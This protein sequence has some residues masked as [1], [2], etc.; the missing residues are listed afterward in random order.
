[1]KEPVRRRP[2]I[3]ACA[4]ALTLI[5]ALALPAQAAEEVTLD[6]SRRTYIV[7]MAAEPVASY[8]GGV[9]GIAAT[10]PEP[11][12]KVDANS[13]NARRYRSH[14][15]DEARRVMRE[16]RVSESAKQ[17]EFEVAFSGF[18]AELTEAQAAQLGKAKGVVHVWEDELRH[19]DTVTTPDY[20]GLTGRRGVWQSEFGGADNA[21]KGM[22]IGVIDSGIDPDNPSFAAARRAK[23]P[24]GPFEC[25]TADDAAFRCSAKIVG[26]RFYGAEYGNDISHDV[27]S[28]RDT[29]GHG[30][31]TAGTAAGNHGV[32]AS[33]LGVDLGRAS[34]M[35]PAAHISVYKALWNTEDGRGT[36]TTSGLVQA[37][38][39]AVADGVDVINYSISGS[40]QYVVT[41][42][43]LAFMAAAHAGVFVS[44]SAGNSGSDGA[45]TVAHNSPWTMTVAASTHDR[46]VT[47]SLRLGNR[48]THKGVGYGGPLRNASMVLARDIPAAGRTA[49]DADLCLLGAVDDRRANGKLVVCTRGTN[50]FV[51]KGQEVQESGGAGMVVVNAPGGST[52]LNAII[53]GIPAIHLDAASG[54]AVK[55]YVS[56]TR[57]PTGTISATR[58][59]TVEAPQM[60]DFSSMGPALAG[61]GDLL[62]P[63]ITAPGVDVIAAYSQDPDTGAPRFES[64]QGTSM[65]AP[66]IAGLALLMKQENPRWSPMAVKSAMMTT[67]RQTTNKGNPISRGGEP[68]TPLDF[69]SGEVVPGKMFDPG[70][71][72][73]SN[74]GDWYVYACG[75]GQ[76]QLLGAAQL[77]DSLPDKDPSDLNYPSISIGSLAG[78]QT[79]TR[80]VTNM[81]RSTQTYTAQVQAPPGTTVKVSPKTIRVPARGTTTFTVTVSRTT[82]P[83]DAYTFGSLT[84]VPKSAKKGSDAGSVRSPIAVRPVLVA[85]PE[86]I[87]G[88]GT[89]GSAT[90]SVT[91][92]FTGTLSTDVDGL[93]ASTVTPVLVTRNPETIL[94]G[95]LPFVVPEGTRV[96]RLATF[97]DEVAAED[98]DLYLYRVEGQQLV[99]VELSG[100]EGSS[101]EV[102]VRDLAPGTYYAIIDLYSPEP[103]VTVPLNVW[104]LGDENAGNLTV[105]PE[106]APVQSSR[107][108]TLTASWSGLD[109]TQRYLGQV[110]YTHECSIGNSTLVTVNP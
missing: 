61:G 78:S 16:A 21:G 52:T 56:R 39:D 20:L 77:C 28:P 58:N 99:S 22:V 92:G 88:E 71:V 3:L 101:E 34:G 48:A 94:D 106:S 46:G 29:N 26:A 17:H 70:L 89:S 97:G 73:D 100:N 74:I 40:T 30:S 24:R 44:T 81:G 51:E 35:A 85:A 83:L 6:E 49:E 66:H 27:N 108:T 25:Q 67:A 109:A 93:L 31:H 2:R 72:Y 38:E 9:P 45:S 41:P 10:A 23:K 65:S 75:I 55:D 54:T 19:A 5:P 95:S 76:L 8:E 91:P 14:L 53:Y 80:T 1:M 98:I 15:K 42:D 11:G 105:A 96:T 110:N 79:V 12:E 84:W 90:L 57:R 86:E 107:A 7:Q 62:K 63:D 33:V 43:E 60:A 82:A 13:S 59:I 32:E 69:G 18:T 87:R 104:N 103:Q 64:L 68:A 102:T 50:P 47:S 37:I 4:V 36:G